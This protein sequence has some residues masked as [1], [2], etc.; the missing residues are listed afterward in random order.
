MAN[1]DYQKAYG[2]T[3][4]LCALSLNVFI[5]DWIDNNKKDSPY[6][7]RMINAL[8]VTFEIYN[9]QNITT[10]SEH[11]LVLKKLVTCSELF[12]EVMAETTDY[13]KY[14]PFKNFLTSIDECP[15]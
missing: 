9:I 7:D 8:A 10:L 15:N 11:D 3:R 13:H 2:D 6:Y 5:G 1:L 12:C 4:T 14:L